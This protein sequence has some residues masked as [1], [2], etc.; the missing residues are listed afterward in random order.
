MAERLTVFWKYLN[1]LDAGKQGGAGK[2]HLPQVP[3]TPPTWP[4]TSP[5]G[6][7]VIRLK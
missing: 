1:K 7:L 5:C 4:C 2:M 3:W 6:N